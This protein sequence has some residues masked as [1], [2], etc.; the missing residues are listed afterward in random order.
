MKPNC[1][2]RTVAKFLCWLFGHKNVISCIDAHY[3][4]THDRC[5]RCGVNLPVGQHK[6]YEDWS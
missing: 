2:R 3:R 5:Q 1:G 6:F 4:Y